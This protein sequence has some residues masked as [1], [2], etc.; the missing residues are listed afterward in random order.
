MARIGIMGS[1]FDPPTYGHLTSAWEMCQRME[2]DRVIFSPS[3]AMRRDK[4]PRVS[5]EHR[6]NMLKLAI[7]D[8]PYFD[9]N[10]HELTMIAGKQYTLYAMR[11]YRKLHPND[12]VFFMLG[13]D[14]LEDMVTSWTH[15]GEL[16]KENNFIV[17]QRNNIDI[18]RIMAQHALLRQYERHF[19]ILYKGMDNDV[20][21]TYVREEFTM[22]HVPRYH[23]PDAVL[24][25]IIQHGLYGAITPTTQEA[26]TPC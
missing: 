17:I 11:Y 9:Y 15:G 3:C 23:M 26:A 24:H 18:P 19:H 14:I 13:A 25:Y 1:S 10:T 2:L 7:A 20:S 16:V 21:S 22:G 6:V 5:D 4:R 8:N 12:E